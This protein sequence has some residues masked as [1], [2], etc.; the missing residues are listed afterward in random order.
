MSIN[1]GRRHVVD[2]CLH[3]G[4]DIQ[5]HVGWKVD[6]AGR[7]SDQVSLKD[8]ECLSTDLLFKFAKRWWVI[9]TGKRRVVGTSRVDEG[10]EAGLVVYDLEVEREVLFADVLLQKVLEKVSKGRVLEDNVEASR[11][12]R[13][14]L[15]RAYCRGSSSNRSEIGDVPPGGRWSIVGHGS[16]LRKRQLEGWVIKDLRQSS[17]GTP[18]CF[19]RVLGSRRCGDAVLVHGPS[20]IALG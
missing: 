19:L 13:H 18:T 11:V 7:V 8:R 12:G 20:S 9:L 3:I 16:R 6:L 2:D 1:R 4:C 14:R 10:V 15:R 17:H 5:A